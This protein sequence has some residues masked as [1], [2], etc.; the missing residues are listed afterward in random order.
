MPYVRFP[1][2]M[3]YYLGDKHEIF[4]SASTMDG[5]IRAIVEQYPAARFHLIDGEGK[6]RR[7]FN[8]FVNGEHIRDLKGMDTPLKDDD[9]VTVLV[10]AAGG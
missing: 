6:L 4:I 5:L 9:K 7:H 3:K 2:V 10:S 8:I 1:A